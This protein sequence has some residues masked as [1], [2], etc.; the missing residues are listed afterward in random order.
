MN[1][2]ISKSKKIVGKL[3]YDDEQRRLTKLV[4]GFSF[5]IYLNNL[6]NL[7]VLNTIK[8]L[9]NGID[10]IVTITKSK[11]FHP[12]LKNF[13]FKANILKN[14]STMKIPIKILS[15]RYSKFP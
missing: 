2:N 7:N 5:E 1:K 9:K 14:I 13:F 4:N 15:K 11:I 6:N 3:Y 12:P 10:E 8:E